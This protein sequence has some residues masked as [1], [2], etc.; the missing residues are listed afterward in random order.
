MQS[1]SLSE[2][3]CKRLVDIM[4]LPRVETSASEV[5]EC[6]GLFQKAGS[7]DFARGEAKSRSKT[8]LELFASISGLSG[9][10]LQEFEM[11]C[12]YMTDRSR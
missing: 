12:T 2:A 4:A 1:A 8:G 5:E 9:E 6:I 10:V 11:I 3:E 7:I